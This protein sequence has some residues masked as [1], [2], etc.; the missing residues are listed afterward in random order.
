[1]SSSVGYP[2][3]YEDGDQRNYSKKEAHEERRTHPGVNVEGY[4]N[5]QAIINELRESEIKRSIEDRI[6]HEPGFAATFHGNKPSRGAQ[7]DAELAREEAELIE[8]K[9]SKTDSLPGKKLEHHTDKSEWKQQ[10]EEEE[11]EALAK[12]SER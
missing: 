9:K 5:K 8:K 2:N 10:M 7:V 12:H 11:K 6:K 4:F 3:I 1:M